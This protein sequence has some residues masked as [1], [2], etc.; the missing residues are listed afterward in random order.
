MGSTSEPAALESGVGP[1]ALG[2]SVVARPNALG[3][4]V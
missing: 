4:D 1:K 3:F 2:S